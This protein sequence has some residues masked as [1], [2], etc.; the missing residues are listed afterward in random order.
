[1]RQVKG[2][3]GPGSQKALSGRSHPEFQSWVCA[4]S[5]QQANRVEDQRVLKG[6]P[7]P[8]V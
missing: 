6:P 2:Q 8:R 4:K 3:V 5:I 1:M 7:E